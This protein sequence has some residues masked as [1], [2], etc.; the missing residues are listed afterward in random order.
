MDL[1]EISVGVPPRPRRSTGRVLSSLV[2]TGLATATAAIFVM[3]TFAWSAGNA[4]ASQPSVQA[5]GGGRPTSTA[6][7]ACALNR[8]YQVTASAGA[9]MIPSNNYVPGTNCSGCVVRID[10]PFAYQWYDLFM[11][12][13]ANLSS[14][15]NLQFLTESATGN[16]LC[17]PQGGIMGA[18]MPYWDDLTTSLAPTMGYYTALVGAAPNRTF[19]IRYFGAK[20]ASGRART[21]EYEVL[22]YEA[23]PRFDIIYGAVGDGGREATIGVQGISGGDGRWTEYSCNAQSITAGTRLRFDRRICL[24]D[25]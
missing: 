20:I 2:F 15:G 25:R 16:N 21:V 22:L 1:P 14:E 6:T 18:I 13:Y 19:V 4:M 11:R 9:T 24:T 10:L 3:F 7:P 23:E 12:S 8:N 5:D 17:L